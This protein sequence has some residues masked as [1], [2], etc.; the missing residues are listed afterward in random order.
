[1]I[2]TTQ[3]NIA[4]PLD[5]LTQ[6]AQGV[7]V[8][9]DDLT[10]KQPVPIDQTGG[11]D[12]LRE[13]LREKSSANQ[14]V[15]DSTVEKPTLAAR[16]T[17][18]IRAVKA[19]AKRAVQVVREA[20]AWV[21]QPLGVVAEYWRNKREPGDYTGR[22]RTAGAWYGQQRSTS[23]RVAI[24]RRRLAGRQPDDSEPAL[25]GPNEYW[26]S[27]VARAIE[28]VRGH[29]DALHPKRGYQFICS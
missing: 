27:H 20:L 9:V 18:F 4:D 14:V 11:L 17:T 5:D 25:P 12:R 6:V 24:Q 28:A 19:W 2:V 7:G 29:E 1:M 26:V 21:A 23:S 16:V 3:V 8:F 10:K 13:I 22:H 15:D